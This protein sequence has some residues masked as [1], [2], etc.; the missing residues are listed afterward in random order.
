MTKIRKLTPLDIAKIQKM[1]DYL[2]PGISS[3]ILS[4]R[5]FTIFPL[6]IL[7]DFLPVQMRFLQ[8]SYVAVEDSELLGLIGLVPDGGQK[9]RWK[10]NRLILNTNAYD[11]GKLLIDYVVNKYG[12]A[13]IETFL[14]AIDENFAEAISLFK[15]SCGFRSCTQIQVWAKDKLSPAQ[16]FEKPDLLRDI[17]PADALHIQDLDQQNLFPQFRPSLSKTVS[18]YRFGLKDTLINN[19]MGHKVK[20]LVSKI[21]ERI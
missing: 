16:N 8:E 3:N 17:K 14:A 12:G 11:I 15:N 20:R 19:F 4:D 7:H 21:P 1:I 5:K 10:I 6:D 2:E 9:I 18:D 13:G